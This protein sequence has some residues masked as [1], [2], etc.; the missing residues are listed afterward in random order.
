MNMQHPYKWP[1]ATHL[2][3]Q[4]ATGQTSAYKVVQQ[5]LERLRA[6]HT[7]LNAATHIFDE[8]LTEAQSPQ[9]GPLSGLPIS[10][11][12]TFGITGH[13]V[14]AGSVRMKPDVHDEDSE[15]VKRVRKAGAIIVARS[16]VPE[17]AMTGET[18]NLRYGRTNNALDS[19]RAAGG[20]SGGEGALVGAGCTAAGLGSDILG[21]IRIPSHFNGIVGFKPASEA[22]EKNGTWPDLQG[23][24]LD[25]WLALGTLTRSVRD[26]RLLYN[27]IAHTP[28][29]PLGNVEGLRLIIPEPFQF[30]IKHPCIWDALKAVRSLLTERGL[31]EEEV[32]F[33]NIGRLFLQLQGLVA[34]TLEQPMMDMLSQQEKFGRPR[35][36]VRQILHRPTVDG[37]LFQLLLLMPLF[38]MSKTRFSKAVQF[39]KENRQQVRDVLRDDGVMLLPTMGMLAPKHGGMNRAS[40]RPGVNGI[41]TPMTFANQMNLP[42]ITI[43]AWRYADQKTGLS[44]SI[45]LLC[46]PGA[47]GRLLDVA[48]LVEAELKA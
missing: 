41:M 2:I 19:T 37:G 21:S 11:K 46:A 15:V 31:S 38:K 8:A 27:V 47:E 42:A 43:P 13:E 45:M 20:S 30:T 5:H 1:D 22:V 4:I 33:P 7:Q 3:E 28:T 9:P 29:P 44:P 12:E 32:P 40:L 18:T 17:F 14:T 10:V 6:T 35:E 39:Y 16:N 36:V 23:A 26:A 24:F 25:S 34:S 48:A